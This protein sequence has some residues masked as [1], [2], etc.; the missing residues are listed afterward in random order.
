M[1]RDTR[2]SN[3]L[4]LPDARW[5]NLASEDERWSALPSLPVKDGSGGRSSMIS[6]CIELPRRSR[7]ESGDVPKSGES[8]EGQ[9]TGEEL[10]GELAETEMEGLFGGVPN[11]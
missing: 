5:S 2:W 4:S 7:R 6:C 9:P 3:L 11:V 1:L 10:R 8:P